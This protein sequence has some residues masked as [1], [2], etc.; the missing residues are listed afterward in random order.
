MVER[1]GYMPSK[2]GRR[3]VEMLSRRSCS[4]AVAFVL[5]GGDEAAVEERC[6]R[7]RTDILLYVPNLQRY[8]KPLER[9]SSVSRPW[10]W[11]FQAQAELGRHRNWMDW[12][13]RKVDG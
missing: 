12:K 11:Q 3:V 4:S 5:S 6:R 13:R 7:A 9:P 10:K 1:S 2:R 8:L